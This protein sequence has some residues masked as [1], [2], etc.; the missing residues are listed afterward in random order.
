MDII[1]L[2]AEKLND[3]VLYDEID[4]SADN[5]TQKRDKF[6]KSIIYKTF[7]D[8][9][10]ESPFVK[11][12]E[13]LLRAMLDTENVYNYILVNMDEYAETNHLIKDQGEPIGVLS[14]IIT[15]W[16]YLRHIHHKDKLIR[17]LVKCKYLPFLMKVFVN[18]NNGLVNVCLY[19]LTND[20]TPRY[21]LYKEHVVFDTN[22]VLG[23]VNIKQHNEDDFDGSY[24]VKE[25]SGKTELPLMGAI[26]H[27]VFFQLYQDITNKLSIIKI[28]KDVWVDANYICPLRLSSENIDRIL[29]TLI[30]I[31]NKISF[32]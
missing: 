22:I 32:K 19:Q 26:R 15:A 28:G 9:A 12:S 10:P 5:T 6:A 4:V 13:R 20:S 14:Y 7:K 24:F 1:P 2:I 16:F 8:M 17:Q 29:G 21:K 3:L 30:R 25:F 11:N 31:R 27:C 18:P 23:F